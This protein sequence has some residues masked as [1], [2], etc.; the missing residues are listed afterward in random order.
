MLNASH[1][2]EALRV[3]RLEQHSIRVNDRWRVCFTWTHQGAIEIEV[4]DYH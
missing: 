1:R 2:L 3:D 4:V